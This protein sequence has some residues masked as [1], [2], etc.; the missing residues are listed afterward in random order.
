MKKPIF[1][2]APLIIPE[3][4]IKFAAQ[5]DDKISAPIAIKAVNS[6]Y[7]VLIGPFKNSGELLLAKQTLRLE[8]NI[9]G[10]CS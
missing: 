4:A 7:K 3:S 2:L 1:K 8:S 9:S 10:L 6:A 5:F